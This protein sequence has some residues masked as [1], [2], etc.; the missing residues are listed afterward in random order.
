MKKVLY[1]FAVLLFCS[2]TYSQKQAIEKLTYEEANKIDY[3]IKVK[4]EVLQEI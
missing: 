3:F 1:L 4:K 2:N